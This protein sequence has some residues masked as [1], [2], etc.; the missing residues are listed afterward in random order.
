ML[1]S[2]LITQIESRISQQQNKIG[3]HGLQRNQLFT[4]QITQSRKTLIELQSL[5]SKAGD[6][7]VTALFT[8]LYLSSNPE[9]QQVHTDLTSPQGID[10][11]FTPIPAEESSPSVRFSPQSS[12][13]SP[14]SAPTIAH[15]TNQTKDTCTIDFSLFKQ[16]T[17]DCFFEN[18]SPSQEEFSIE[19]AL[20]EITAQD[21]QHNAYTQDD[22]SDTNF[23]GV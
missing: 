5:L 13:S 9:P 19:L 10:N 17:D 21:D 16:D 18:N 23:F 1:L 6:I 3:Y 20:S 15:C 8:N 12:L 4:N 2:E 14:T 22:D 11:P 7:K